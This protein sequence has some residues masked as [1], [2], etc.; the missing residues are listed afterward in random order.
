ML[1]AELGAR[2]RPRADD[3]RLG[4]RARAR[5]GAAQGRASSGSPRAAGSAGSGFRRSGGPRR[6]GA[7]A[8]GGCPAASLAIVHLPAGL[9]PLALDG[10][11]AAATRRAASRRSSKRPAAGGAGRD[12][13]SRAVASLHGSPRGRSAG[14]PRA[15]RSPGSSPAAGRQAGARGSLAGWSRTAPARSPRTEAR[16]CRWCSARR[17]RS[18]SRP[19]CSSALGGALTG[20]ARAQRAADLAA[21]SGARSL[22]DDFPRLFAPPRLPERRAEPAPSGQGA[23]IWPEPRRR[24]ARPRARNGV[25][26]RRLRVSFPDA[27]S[28]APLRVRAEVT[29]SVDRGALPG[30]RARRPGAPRPPAAPSGSRPAP[31]PRRRRPA[32]ADGG[33]RAMATGG[34]YSGPLA[35]RQGKPM[36]PDVAAAFDRLAAAARRDGDRAGDQLGLPLRRRAGAAVRRSTPTRAGWRRRASRFTA[37]RPSSTSGRRPP[38]RGWPRTRAASASCSATAGSRGTSASR[39]ARRPCSA[40]PATPAATGRRRRRDGAP[41]RAAGLRARR[42]SAAPILRSAAR[43][44]VSAGAARR[45]A[46]GRVQL[47]PVRGLAAPARRGSPSSCPGPPPPTASTTRSTPPAA[48]DA[49]A[50]LMS[51]LLRQFGVACRSPSPPTTPARRRWPPATASRRSPRPRPTSPASSA[52]WAA[53]GSWRRPTLEVRLV[54]RAGMKP[55]RVMNQ[56]FRFL[57]Q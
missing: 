39:A 4:A 26:P 19:R 15:V 36:R 57:S 40:R 34:G 23:S 9:W 37:A 10:P 44:N 18:C 48:I 30:P 56:R 1:L 3:A 6:A 52:C 32:G 20:T 55:G 2:A 46:D 41:A 8:R 51:D 54:R 29:A 31:R 53:R 12:R 33:S 11:A 13:A 42:A 47:Q 25:D 45:A 17:S 14:S 49:Q 22:R 50:H 43:W 16:R 35:Y 7:G 38:T 24:R 21:L 27:G 5:A 28:F